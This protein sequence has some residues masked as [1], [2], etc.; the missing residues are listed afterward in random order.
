MNDPYRYFRIEARELIDELDKGIAGLASGLPATEAVARLLRAAHTLKG[1]ARVVKRPEIA[2][3]AHALEDALGPY[4]ESDQPVPRDRLAPII[5][6]VASLRERVAALPPPPE[7]APAADGRP[8]Q[9]E[10]LRT[11]RSDVVEMDEL[12]EE[13]GETYTRLG[14]IR[15]DV[16]LIE[17]ARNLADLIVQQLAPH[18]TGDQ[19]STRGV[20]AEK[21]RS[22]AVELRDV[23]DAL[24]Q[25]LE[26]SVD[27]VERH[28]RQVKSAAERL[29]LEAVVV[30]FTDTKRAGQDVAQ[31]QGKRVIF[32]EM[33]SDMRLDAHVVATIQP[34]LHQ[35]VRNAVAHGIESE[36][37][38]RTAGK[39]PE[40]KVTLGVARRGRHV[41]FMCRDDGRGVDLDAVRST[42]QRK[43]LFSVAT[44]NLGP[45]ELVRLLLK[46]GISTSGTVTEVSGRGIGLD[47]VRDSVM[48]LGGEVIVQ[49]DAGTGTTVE[50]E[51]PLSVAAL[52][53]LT[54]EAGDI[55]VTIPLDAVRSALRIA[56]GE[57]ASSSEGMSLVYE[58][59]PVPFVSLTTVF[60]ADPSPLRGRSSQTVMIVE[61]END[62]AA[63]GIDR[64][65]GTSSIVVRPLPDLK[66]GST[67]VSGVWFDTEGN[68]QLVLD[69]DGL[70]AEARHNRQAVVAD[71]RRLLPILVIDDSLTTRMLEL[72]ILE[73]A[74]YEVDAV[75]SAE[76]AV[77]RARETRY[78]LFLVDIELPDMDGFT[79][80][81]YIRASATLSEIPCI[82]MTS[83]GSA[84]DRRRG[85]DAGAD[86]YIAKGEFD[87]GEFLGLIRDLV[88]G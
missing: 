30:L 75:S 43:G 35:L 71:E 59:K 88:G 18:H 20:S 69:P 46:G 58:E 48:R 39:P 61:G 1:A 54:V 47:V 5:G 76:E 60:G 15:G 7:A 57:I 56:S 79:F 67:I 10:A 38:R 44:A 64:L 25:G 16:A 8:Q 29:R 21:A 14:S 3:H 13:V 70:A 4:R 74:G 6:I 40:G 55:T 27:R 65:L 24:E 37:E 87:Q 73:T 19:R 31:A 81:E 28:L 42:V 52:D 49:T 22:I 41:V 82:I 32:E 63:I 36:N 77:E 17:R 66:E 11:V 23:T 45:E 72:S 53:V 84:A 80:V 12:L 2:D 86:A 62:L 68:P 26:K 85:L 50:L 34:A 33:G 51:I 9:N 78:A 83:R